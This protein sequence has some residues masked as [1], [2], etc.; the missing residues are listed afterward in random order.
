MRAREGIGHIFYTWLVVGLAVWQ[1][2]LNFPALDIDMARELLTI[3]FLGVLAEWFAVCFPHGQ[4]SGGFALVLS[5]YLIYGQAAVVWVSGLATLLGQGIANRGNPLRTT[6]FNAGQYALAA[7]VAGY[8]FEQSGGI[9]GLVDV[10]NFLPLAAFT[11][12]FIVANHLMVYFYMLPERHHLPYASWFDTIKWDGLTYLFTVP[13]GLLIAMIYGYTGLA[14]TLLV[15]ISVLALQLILRFYVGLQVANKEMKAFYEVARLLEAKPD[16]GTVLNYV[17]KKAGRIFYYHTGV[18]YLCSGEKDTYLPAAATGPYTEQLQF[19]AI[20]TG[21]GIIGQSLISKEPEIIFDSRTDPRVKNEDVLCRVLRSLLIIPLLS[22]REVLGVIVLGDKRPLAF[23]EKHLHIM[24][25]LGGQVAIA[26]ENFILNHRL[27]QVLSRDSLT[28]LLNFGSF[29]EAAREICENAVEKGTPVGMIIINID[30]FKVFSQR[31]G[32]EAGERVL[33][34]TAYLIEAC[35]RE[36]DLVARYGGDEFM[37]LLPG[38]NGQRL[39]NEAKTLLEEIRENVFLRA[40]GRAARLT[41]SSGVAEFPQDAG[42]I[43][44]L[45]RAAQR[46][47]EKAKTAG[48]DRVEPAAAPLVDL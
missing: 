2:Y 23:D 3:V 17:L 9:Q 44:G 25:V 6:L 11:V 37:L 47:L 48:G 7:V 8:V 42:D 38:A 16:P 32:C 35:T 24:T 20:Y 18:A 27:K 15:F 31:Y 1:L 41:A 33:A 34:E 39:L 46:A 36:G 43:A 40:E 28:G 12:S 29:L 30:R 19:T 5:T 10:A 26:V 45:F 13:I 4:L 22:G 14:G 21:E